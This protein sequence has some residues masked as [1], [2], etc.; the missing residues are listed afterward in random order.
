MFFIDTIPLYAFLSSMFSKK[1][2]IIFLAESQSYLI[3]SKKD[4]IVTPQTKELNWQKIK[5]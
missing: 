3:L 2:K 5:L 1:S 4:F